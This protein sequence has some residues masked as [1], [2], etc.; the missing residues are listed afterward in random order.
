MHGIEHQDADTVPSF[1]KG[2]VQSGVVGAPVPR[3]KPDHI[4]GHEDR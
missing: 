1:H 3:Y 4:L 2:G